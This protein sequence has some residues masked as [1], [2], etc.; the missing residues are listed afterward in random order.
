MN[1]TALETMKF[2]Y[3]IHGTIPELMPGIAYRRDGKEY[4][5]DRKVL[6]CPICGKRLTDMSKETRVELYQHPE[7]VSVICQFYIKCFYCCC[8]V[9]INVA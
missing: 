7:R 1:E 3:I 8:E 6:K 2:F 5:Y 9:G 4:L